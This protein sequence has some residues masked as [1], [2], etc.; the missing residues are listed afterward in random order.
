MKKMIIGLM[1]SVA[2]LAGIMVAPAGA[3]VVFWK[4]IVGI[5]ERGNVV[6]SGVG[7][8]TGGIPWTTRAFLQGDGAYVDLATGDI[9]FTVFGLVLAAGNSIGTPGAVT[10]VVGTLVCDTN[11]SASG[12]DSVLV[13]TAAVPLD[14]QGNAQFMGNIGPLPN[15]CLIEEDMAFLIRN[16]TS[17]TPANWIA[18][19]A[20][21]VH[22]VKK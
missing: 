4:D 21:K 15:A 18:N 6:G 22:E 16:A 9:T 11:G 8:V 3:D 20:V 1:V 13:N 2:L 5:I 17:G 10:A 19:G 12:G 14:S 7:M